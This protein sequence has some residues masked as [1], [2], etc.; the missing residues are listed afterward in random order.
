MST[1]RNDADDRVRELIAEVA[2]TQVGWAAR[3]LT[4]RVRVVEALA[5]ILGRD[6]SG[7]ATTITREMG[8]PISQAE[9][10]IDKCIAACGYYTANIEE[11]LSPM[12]IASKF[13]RSFVRFDPLGVVLGVM[14]WNYPFWQV[15]RL[16]VPAIL[17]GNTVLL[18]HAA[19]V[20]ACADAIEAVV[21]EAAGVA[22]LRGLHIRP[23]QVEQVIADRR[24]EAVFVTASSETGAS[25][26]RS[27]AGHLKR[28][29]LELGGSDAFI[30]MPDADVGSAA[31]EAVRARMLNAGQS[32]V[33]A[34]RFLVHSSVHAE[35]A[36]RLV[37][38]I[39][40][41]VVGDPL[42]RGTDVGPLARSDLAVELQRQVD[43]SVALGAE[44][45]AGGHRHA[46]GPRFYQPTVL[47]GVRPGM[48]A[49]DEETF[50]PV[51]SLSGYDD[52]DEAIRLANMS[53]Y[54]LGASIW[55]QKVDEAE[56]L[57]ARLNVGTVF[58]NSRVSSDPGLPFGGV[59][60]SGYGR[61]MGIFG[62]REL[63]NIKAVAV[64]SA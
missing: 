3:G 30:V 16:V 4:D 21:T 18:K 14:P 54:G 53:R 7:L 24:V 12:T 13:D 56:R 10:E 36:T 48:P 19:N 5:S 15:L 20:P 23:D 32:C 8:K 52:V 39:R 27:A 37:D 29:V 47:D 50:G 17:C 6:R 45:L 57:A 41:L 43:E 35:F 44:V 22:L 51:A 60:H 1:P 25:V 11:F 2:R 33:S 64:R 49:F 38:G 55:T 59:K 31:R 46:A 9:D 28:Q 61:E 58:V 26:A 40:A 62:V 42:D 63:T 34:K